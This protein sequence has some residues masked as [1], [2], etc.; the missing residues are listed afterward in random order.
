MNEVTDCAT[1]RARHDL[2]IAEWSGAGRPVGHARVSELHTI[3]REF[4]NLDSG[5]RG[6]GGGVCNSLRNHPLR[7]KERSN[8]F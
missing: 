2:R 7:T 3:A 8:Y 4:A 6:G 1:I 5:E